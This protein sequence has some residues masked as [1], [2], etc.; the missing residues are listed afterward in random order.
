MG[1][2]ETGKENGPGG[3]RL[4]A[5]SSGAPAIPARTRSAMVAGA[6]SQDCPRPGTSSW[7]SHVHAGLPADPAPCGLSQDPGPVGSSQG[8]SRGLRQLRGGTA[9]Q[10]LSLADGTGIIQHHVHGRSVAA[11]RRKP[12]QPPR[13]RDAALGPLLPVHR[14]VTGRGGPR[15]RGRDAPG[16]RVPRHRLLRPLAVVEPGSRGH[17]ADPHP[18]CSCGVA[19]GRV[20]QADAVPVGRKR[21]PG[22]PRS[23]SADA[24]GVPGRSGPRPGE[25]H[26]VR[27][28][29][30]PDPAALGGWRGR[31]RRPGLQHAA[32]T[33]RLAGRRWCDGCS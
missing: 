31:R 30:E 16:L 33:P 7:R 19:I 6:R 8:I 25:R 5:Q 28:P 12:Q 11:L 17:H 15:D 23:G 3:C 21:D 4:P 26:A 2:D 14:P 13:V 22:V 9:L 32:G 27:H 20:S 1:R 24:R 10:A 18:L 29:L